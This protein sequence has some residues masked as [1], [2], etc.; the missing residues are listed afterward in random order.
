MKHLDYYQKAHT[1]NTFQGCSVEKFAAEIKQIIDAFGAKSLLDYGCGQGV[2][3]ITNNPKKYRHGPSFEHRDKPLGEYWGIKVS[4]YDP[5]VKQHESLPGGK[6][7]GVISIDVLEHV[8][9]E[10][11]EDMF[12]KIFA[13]ARKFVFFSFCNRPANKKFPDGTNVHV[14]LHNHDWWMRKIQQYNHNGV[15]VY[16]RETE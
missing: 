5:G 8:P 6:F 1:K 7:D 2:P 15:A 16:L 4:L 3:Y 13:R 10:E 14:T 9:E 12:T 11:L